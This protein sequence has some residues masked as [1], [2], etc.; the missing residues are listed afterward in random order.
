MSMQIS[1]LAEVGRQTVNYCAS[2]SLL[3]VEVESTT[4]TIA[5]GRVSD[6]FIILKNH[7]VACYPLI[8]FL[9]PHTTNSSQT[10]HLDLPFL[11]L[12]LQYTKLAMP[13]ISYDPSPQL[14]SEYSHDSDCP[15]PINKL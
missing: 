2:V 13:V 9:T 8:K 11:T 15:L 12:I 10:F 14:Y 5:V 7:I 4:F 1:W 6:E 3:E